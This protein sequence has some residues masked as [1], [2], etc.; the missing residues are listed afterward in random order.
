MRA[1]ELLAIRRGDYLEARRFAQTTRRDGGNPTI[2][3]QALIY[4]RKALAIGP[5]N[6]PNMYFLADAILDNEPAHK[7]E[8]RRLLEALYAQGGIPEVL[9]RDA[10]HDFLTRMVEAQAGCS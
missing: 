5:R 1:E 6:T 3:A 4:L 9:R 8:A 2:R 7:D 10:A